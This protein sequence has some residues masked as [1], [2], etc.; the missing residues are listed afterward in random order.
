MSDT[1]DDLDDDQRRKEERQRGL[2]QVH[3]MLGEALVAHEMTDEDSYMAMLDIEA[4]AEHTAEQ[5]RLQKMLE[6]DPI[7]TIFRGEDQWMI[8][9]TES[10][11]D[12][13]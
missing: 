9:G 13:E 4:E 7:G 2:E 6:Q 11:D 3:G 1:N 5:E 10:D 12:A 8:E